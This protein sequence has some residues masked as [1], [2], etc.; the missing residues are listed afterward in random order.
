[1][2]IDSD[3][4]EKVNIKKNPQE[5]FSKC[6]N[7]KEEFKTEKKKN[8]ESVS[9]LTETQGIFSSSSHSFGQDEA[10][11]VEKQINVVLN[12]TKNQKSKKKKSVKS[13][14]E[15]SPTKSRDLSTISEYLDESFTQRIVGAF[16]NFLEKIFFEKSNN[17]AASSSC[18][19]H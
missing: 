4:S 7:L 15:K 3:H 19:T 17:S 18:Y 8:R 9:D 16:I 1:M 10:K 5:N 11:F 2:N 6:F 13:R 14:E 12:D